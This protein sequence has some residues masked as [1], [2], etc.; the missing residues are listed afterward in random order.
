MRVTKDPDVRRKELI[1]AAEELFREKGCEE[2]SVSDIV[3]KVGVAQGT[4]Y[5]YFESKDV[6]LDAVLDHYLMDHLEP[7]IRGIMADASLDAMQKI[8]LIVKES[9]SFQTGERKVM[10]FLH[11]DRNM[12]SHQKYMLKVRDMFVPVITEVLE[13]GIEEGTFAVPYPRE[14][15]ELL[16]VMF[17]YLHDSA[18]L[19][20]DGGYD[21][22]MRAAEDIAVKVLGLKDK[23]IELNI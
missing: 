23:G 1:D 5:Y 17:A 15:A 7:A 20:A 18:A 16:L 2:T 14:T 13:E 10:E 9:L 11:A 3:R 22:K 12:A 8:Q 6:I 4:F 21:R 19:S